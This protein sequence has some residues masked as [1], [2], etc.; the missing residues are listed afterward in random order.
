MTCLVCS[1]THPKSSLNALTLHLVAKSSTQYVSYLQSPELKPDFS[2]WSGFPYRCAIFLFFAPHQKYQ[3][4]N[5]PSLTLVG[6]SGESQKKVP[7]RAVCFP[8]LQMCCNMNMKCLYSP[9]KSNK[10]GWWHVMIV[11]PLFLKE[12]PL[13]PV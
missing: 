10:H 1:N 12:N 7:G 3:V 6:H 4:Y 5:G 8:K 11:E 2:H 9:S 13:D